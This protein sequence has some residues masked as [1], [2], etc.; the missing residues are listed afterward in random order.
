[1][2][3]SL[4]LSGC[5][6]FS[7][8]IRVSCDQV[9]MSNRGH[10]IEEAG[11][12][13]YFRLMEII[14]FLHRIRQFKLQSPLARWGIYTKLD[15]ISL[16]LDGQ[17][18]Q[19][20]SQVGRKFDSNEKQT[21]KVHDTCN[22]RSMLPCFHSQSIHTSEPRLAAVSKLTD[23]RA[24]RPATRPPSTIT[25]ECWQTGMS[26]PPFLPSQFNSSQF[27]SL[28]HQHRVINLHPRQQLYARRHSAQKI[29]LQLIPELRSHPQLIAAWTLTSTQS[30]V[31]HAPWNA[32]SYKTLNPI[33]CEWIPS[34]HLPPISSFNTQ[35][36]PQNR[37][38]YDAMI[39]S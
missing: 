7:I 31:L 9:Q 27:L 16:L 14:L 15:L 12:P 18:W 35:Y 39:P 21:E 17:R 36:S 8:L 30:T 22:Q 4:R 3:N 32:A 28:H 5:D 37:N 1:M 25:T 34:H 19:R 38:P 6:G 2:R 13:A 24:G 33:S 23:S 26:L 10:L 20:S 29:L 11:W